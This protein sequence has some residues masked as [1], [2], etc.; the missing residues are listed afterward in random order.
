MPLVCARVRLVTGILIPDPRTV[1]VA[2]A[3]TLE[4][5]VAL[6]VTVADPA[7]RPVTKPL[8]ETVATWLLLVLHVSVL[9]KAVVGATVAVNW[10]VCAIFSVTWLVLRVIQVTGILPKIKD[11]LTPLMEPQ[12]VQLS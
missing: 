8:F 5:S 7:V 9:L 1:I 3:D 6:A 11:R 10:L 2:V 12:P 4:P